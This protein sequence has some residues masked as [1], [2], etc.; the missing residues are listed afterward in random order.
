MTL[1][2]DDTSLTLV[3]VGGG[4]IAALKL[5]SVMWKQWI[6]TKSDARDERQSTHVDLGY[7]EL[8]ADLRADVERKDAIIARQD[9]M[10]MDR[11]KALEMQRDQ[12]IELENKLY[13]KKAP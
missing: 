9:A 11:D 10:I 1:P 13:R 7:R 8:I 4:I 5:A 2:S 3:A 6:E 12:I